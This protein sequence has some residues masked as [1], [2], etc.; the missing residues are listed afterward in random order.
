MTAKRSLFAALLAL[1]AGPQAD[2]GPV[3][4]SEIIAR[5]ETWQAA[6]ALPALELV[7]AGQAPHTPNGSRIG[8]PVWL[9]DGESWPVDAGGKRMTFLAQIDFAALP[10]LPD[11]PTSGVL[12][13]FIARDDL[14]GLNF[15]NP[16]QGGFKVIFRED[17]TTPGRLETGPVTEG[18]RYVDDFSPLDPGIVPKGVALTAQPFTHRPDIGVWQFH[19]AV[20]K[21]LDT[22]AHDALYD[23][24]NTLDPLKRSNWRV[25]GHPEFTQSDWR[26]ETAFRDVDRVLLHLWTSD[27]VLMWGDS[28]Q[29]HFAI[30]REDLLKRDFSKVFYNWDCY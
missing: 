24:I 9:P 16:Q 27:D 12:Q 18:Q 20:G 2:A 30:R 28:G 14:Y 13:F 15:E 19:E 1:F 6:N 10:P 4:Q 7:P 25:G 29:G 21:H 5:Y 17:L 3:L 8:G 22:A 23:H 26:Y 11:Y